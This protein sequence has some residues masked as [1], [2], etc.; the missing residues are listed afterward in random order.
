MTM[1]FIFCHIPCHLEQMLPNSGY[2]IRLLH[3]LLEILQTLEVREIF[4]FVGGLRECDGNV[5]AGDPLVEIV[6]NLDS[7]FISDEEVHKKHGLTIV[8]TRAIVDKE[9][10]SS[11]KNSGCITPSSFF[12]RNHVLLTSVWMIGARNMPIFCSMFYSGVAKD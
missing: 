10:I 8:K 3:S 6:F 1:I 9:S 5:F 4:L 11:S 7:E 2:N 12:P